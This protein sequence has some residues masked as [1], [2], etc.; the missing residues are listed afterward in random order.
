MTIHLPA[1]AIKAIDKIRRGFLWRGRKEA[2]GGHRLIAWPIVCQP[3]EFG[4]FGIFDLKLLSYALKGEMALDAKKE[5]LKPW[6]TFPI[7]RDRWLFGQHIEEVAPRHFALV[8]KR[9]VNKR[10][11]LQALTNRSWI[12]DIQGAFSIV[13]RGF[14]WLMECPLLGDITTRVT[15]HTFLEVLNFRASS[16]ACEH[17]GNTRNNGQSNAALAAILDQLKKMEITLGEHTATITRLESNKATTDRK[18]KGIYS[19]PGGG[20]NDGSSDGKGL[21]S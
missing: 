4:C 7:R 9:K 17:V 8:P 2:S 3:Q 13:V 16:C 21:N 12:S 15:G 19:H 14:S 6:S 10:T 5:P 11:V 18:A 20:H 1:W